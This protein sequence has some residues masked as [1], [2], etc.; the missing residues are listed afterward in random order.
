ML[1]IVGF[2][3]LAVPKEYAKRVEITSMQRPFHSF[4]VGLIAAVLSP[5]A[6]FVL[7]WTVIGIPLGVILSMAYLGLVIL[8]MPVGAWFLGDMILKVFD[9]DVYKYMKLV[10]G[11]IAFVLIGLIPVVGPII[12]LITS[13]IGFGAM[14][15]NFYGKDKPKRRTKRRKR[16]AVVK[17]AKSSSLKKPSKPK[18]LKSKKAN[19]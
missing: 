3:F 9:M 11:A 8:S 7:L 14:V 18:S 2:V 1:L 17:K 15:R 4:V 13:I 6:I 12:L 19:K 10:L 16:R 5:L